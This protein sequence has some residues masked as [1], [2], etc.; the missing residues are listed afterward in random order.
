PQIYPLAPTVGNA[1]VKYLKEVRPQFCA[2]RLNILKGNGGSI[3]Q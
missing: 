1:I 3:D 2:P